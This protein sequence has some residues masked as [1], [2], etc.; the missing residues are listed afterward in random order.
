MTQTA[1]P[2]SHWQRLGATLRLREIE[3]EK[4][5]ILAAYPELRH[6][7]AALSP[8]GAPASAPRWRAPENATQGAGRRRMSPEAKKRMSEG[9]RKWW[10]KRK[11]AG[12]KSGRAKA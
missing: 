11:A 1:T 4:A 9:M 10:A 6:G 8:E 2:E 7:Q 3:E 5:Q 12:V